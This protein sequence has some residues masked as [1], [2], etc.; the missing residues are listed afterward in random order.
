MLLNRASAF[1]RWFIGELKRR[2]RSVRRRWHPLTGE[3]IRRVLETIHPP[4]CRILMVHSSLSQCGTIAGGADT[5]IA[6][7]RRWLGDGGHLAM[8]TH[9][10]CYP[11]PDGRVP[12]FDPARTRSQVGAIT[13]CF[14]RRPDVVRSIHPSHSLAILGP[15]AQEFCAGHQN[16]RT[17]CGA[18]TPYDR[19]IQAHAAVLM[20]GATL[21]TYTFFHTA[22]DAA[23]VP[24]L[25]EPRTYALRYRDSA[26]RLRLTMTRRQDF[27][28]SRCF[29]ERADW[30]ADQDLLSRHRLGTGELL[31]LPH[32]LHV[33]TQTTEMLKHDSGFL[34][35]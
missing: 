33:H 28:V 17:P 24:Y 3:D 7:L 11:S 27:T 13:N 32:A 21:H 12:I 9:T 8:P 2:Q 26:R 31:Y 35:K 5:V 34:L 1:S 4:P 22:E 25:Y 15:R 19:L 29:A 6:E 16:C 23:E 18:G 14:W 20:F 30:L 10:Y